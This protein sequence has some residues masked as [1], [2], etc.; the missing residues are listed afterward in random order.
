MAAVTV[1]TGEIRADKPG[2]EVDRKDWPTLLSARKRFCSNHFQA[3]CGMLLFYLE[4]GRENGYFGYRDET[5]Y[6]R[7]GLWLEPEAV[8]FAAAYLKAHRERVRGNPISFEEAERRGREELAKAARDN[9]LG[10]E[11]GGR[12]VKDTNHSNRIVSKPGTSTAYIL[13]RLARDA[14]EV[15]SAYERGEYKSARA[16]AIAAGIIKP[17]TRLDILR[18]TWKKCTEEERDAFRAEI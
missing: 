4:D 10:N 1:R 16:A 3:D 8:T 2:S 15:L 5:E 9:P 17:A 14:P 6:C 18:R 11:K 13:R 7:E 12:P